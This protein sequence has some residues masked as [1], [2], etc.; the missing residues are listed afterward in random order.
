[1]DVQ[2][3]RYYAET[4]DIIESQRNDMF[5]LLAQSKETISDLMNKALNYLHTFLKQLFAY[6]N[7]GEC[8]INNT[9]A[10]RTIQT[11]TIQRKNSM[12]I[13]SDQMF[14]TMLFIIRLLKP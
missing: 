7:H 14:R 2:L 6:R 10:E 11:I 1:M 8:T 13:R 3:R 5:D 4:T 12:F 9:A